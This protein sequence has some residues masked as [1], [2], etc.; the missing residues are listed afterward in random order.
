MPVKGPKIRLICGTC[1]KVMFRQ[2]SLVPKGPLGAFC[3]RKCL[4][5]GKRVAFKEQR[6]RAHN[7][8]SNDELI[9]ELQSLA[10]KLGYSPLSVEM[11]S[12]GKYSKTIYF[13]RFGSWKNALNKANLP[14]P[15][16]VYRNDK[17]RVVFYFTNEE[18]LAQLKSF[19]E[20]LGHTPTCTE[21]QKDGPFHPNI[22]YKR[23]G[24]YAKA[25]EL[26]GLNPHTT[27]EGGPKHVRWREYQK[28]DGSVVKL[29]GTY[30]YR[31]ACVLDAFEWDWLAHGEF[32]RLRYLDDKGNNRFFLPDFYIPPQDT[33]YDT[34][35]WF[36]PNDQQRMRM[37][38]KSN[39]GLK[40]IIVTKP[41][42]MCYEAAAGIT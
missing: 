15:K 3:S 28:P 8:V 42:L 31:F 12:L 17:R 41:I 26:T 10:Q 40:L 16:K 39:P 24:S 22:L 37:F 5:D 6:L 4:A 21:L 35:G 11:D 1:A 36:R 2:P 14:P 27:H 25:C 29:Q 30:E 23:F 18:L 19:A 13:R 33:Y 20:Q 32:K 34:K 7:K 38:R 9:S